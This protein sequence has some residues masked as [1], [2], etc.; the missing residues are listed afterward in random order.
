MTISN[1]VAILGSGMTRFGENFEQGYFDL[2]IEAAQMA[3]RDAKIGQ[4][5]I[6][7]AWLGTAFGY[8]YTSEGN[9][10][11]SLGEPLSLYD[12]P[13]TRVSNYCATGMDAIR[14]A[15]MA[16]A[17]G[18][19]DIAI[20]VGVEKMRDVEPR[21]SLVSQH[22]G[23]GH[24]VYSKGRT[25]PGMFALMGTRY[26]A[27]Y[28]DPREA[29]TAVAM[30]NHHNGRLNPRAHFRM[31][32]SA[33]QVQ[34]SPLVA[35]PLRLLDCC[36]TTDGAAA[37]VLARADLAPSITDSYVLL[38]GIG[39]A[40]T[41][42]YFSAQFDP[43]WDFLGFPATRKA[44]ELAYSQAGIADPANEIDVAEVHDCFTVTE[45][46]NYEDLGLCAPGLGRRFVLDG[47]ATLGGRLPVNTS[48]GLKSCGHPI[49][50]SGVRMVA[51]ISD[52]LRERAGDSQVKNART[53]MAHTLG[54]PGS[55][56][57]VAILRRPD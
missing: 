46:L 6:D 2:V 47:H 12:I 19:C 38:Q 51:N 3:I 7:G 53:G 18:E 16:I 35:P 54:G 22:V 8:T 25:A 4:E 5:A 20:A 11:P 30:K 27:V 32:V 41:S 17:A 33:D 39:L 29:M 36:P 26:G 55:V 57:C 48:G 44:A 10:G 34:A 24:P 43:Q 1:Q 37:V 28:G 31:E 9:G 52:Q 15:A 14:N 40:V 21:G 42:G 49:G 50:A 45:I 56:S 23:K 13:I